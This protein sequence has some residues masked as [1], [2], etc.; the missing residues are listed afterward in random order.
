VSA[1]RKPDRM[2]CAGG[3]RDWRRGPRSAFI[4]RL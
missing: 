3:A 2:T 1:T 4:W